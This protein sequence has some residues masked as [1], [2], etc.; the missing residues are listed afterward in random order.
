MGEH[1]NRY[2]PVAETLVQRGFE[3]I[4]YDQNGHGLTGGPL[5]DFET[6]L[7]DLESV[8][9]KLH[10]ERIPLIPSRKIFLYGQSMGGGLVLRYALEHPALLAGVVASSPLIRTAEP[11]PRW[12]IGI[13][14]TLGRFFP[15]VSLGTSVHPAQLTRI[16]EAQNL[17]SS[18]PLIHQRVSAI[19]GLSMLK[20]G[21]WISE[22][23]EQLRVPTLLMHGTA[24]TITSHQASIDFARRA[25]NVCSLKL[26]TGGLHDLHFDADRQDVLDHVGNFLISLL[27]DVSR[28]ASP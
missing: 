20:A 9:H 23:A 28:G 3:V 8:A 14:R 21:K 27:D 15:Q 13:G 4:G 5:P 7:R 18:D 24:D 12:K 19:L 1:A 26:W 25:Q 22:H 17:Y 10:L 16:P 6:L 2:A 11:P